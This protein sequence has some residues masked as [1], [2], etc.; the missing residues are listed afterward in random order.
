M[1]DQFVDIRKSIETSIL[2]PKL[3]NVSQLFP[4]R[5]VFSDKVYKK[6]STDV[7][8]YVKY[9]PEDQQKGRV[10]TDKIQLLKI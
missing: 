6:M 2:E 5:N 9:I 1:I 4:L 7:L 3:N 8:R 10:P